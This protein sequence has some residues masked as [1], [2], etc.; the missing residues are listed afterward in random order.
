[1][2]REKIKTWLRRVALS[3]VAVLAIASTVYPQVN[4]TTPAKSA[5]TLPPQFNFLPQ[6]PKMMKGAS[7]RDTDFQNSVNAQIGDRVAVRVFYHNGVVD[8]FAHNTRIK[9]NIPGDQSNPIVLSGSV[10]SD[11]TNPVT[12]TLNINLPDSLQGRAEFV[13]G[14]AKWFPNALQQ[15]Q[16]KGRIDPVPFPGGQS[17][18][19]VVGPNGV[20][21]GTI[22]GCFEYAGYVS[23]LVDIK[24][25]A[26]ITIN[27]KVA[28]INSANFVDE[29]EAEPG[30]TVVFKINVKNVGNDV[31][32]DVRV[33]DILPDGLIFV[34]DTI[35]VSGGVYVGV[36]GLFQDG[37]VTPNFPPGAEAVIIFRAKVNPDIDRSQCNAPLI[38]V[39]KL[40]VSGV[41]KGEAQARVKVICPPPVVPGLAIEKFVWNGARFDKSSTAKVGDIVDYQLRIKNIGNIPIV[42]AF[43]TDNI[44]LFADYIEGS[45]RVNGNSI[46]NDV[47]IN[48]NAGLH[49]G[50]IIGVLQPGQEVIIEFK[51]K[52]K[53][54][55]P[56]QTVV[57]RNVGYVRSDETG[58]A[59]FQDSVTTTV[60]FAVNELPL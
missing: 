51:I 40:F 53:G 9:V 21:I 37:I 3:S 20:N 45:T 48:E 27:K 38:N 12:D 39:A 33:K 54:C 2:I 42:D 60:I 55:P 7:P 58:S 46:N 56:D 1:M 23:L 43:V 41:F 6:D 17:G 24:G 22:Q 13:P 57:L 44:P 52:V 32:H 35:T 5:G 49:L 10:D 26:N 31:A 19:E 8:S 30:E 47:W 4:N 36:D 25:Q 11:E 59:V 34:P 16:E 18:D 28:K 14:S 50:Q 29:I 15:Y